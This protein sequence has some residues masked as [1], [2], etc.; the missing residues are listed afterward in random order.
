MGGREEDVGEEELA[1]RDGFTVEFGET[2]REGCML[3]PARGFALRCPSLCVAKASSA[4]CLGERGGVII[5][6][7]S[8]F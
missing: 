4:G 1:G 7:S 6:P 2:G 8:I 3:R 5:P